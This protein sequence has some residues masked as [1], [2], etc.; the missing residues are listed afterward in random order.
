[1][2]RLHSFRL[3]LGGDLGLVKPDPAIFRLTGERLGVEPHEIVLLDDHD[4]HVE[5]ARAC[6]WH[7]VWHR[8]STASIQMISKIIGEA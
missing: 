3:G 1:M 7:A 2:K 4:G 5:A 6:G 8:D